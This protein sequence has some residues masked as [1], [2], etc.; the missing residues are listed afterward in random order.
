MRAK[1]HNAIY[2]ATLCTAIVCISY[3]SHTKLPP[4][5]MRRDDS[6]A[7]LGAFEI[8]ERHPALALAAEPPFVLTDTVPRFL[9][10]G[11]GSEMEQ[12]Q[13]LLTRRILKA[14]TGPLA[15]Q[16]QSRLIA[17][18]VGAASGWYSLYWASLG[19]PVIAFEPGDITNL[20]RAINSNGFDQYI[21]VHNTGISAV[22]NHG[23][24]TSTSSPALIETSMATLLPTQSEIIILKIDVE[25]SEMGV[26]QDV[27]TLIKNG[28]KIHNIIVEVTPKWWPE[29]TSAGLDVFQA[30]INMKWN[31]FSSPWSEHAARVGKPPQGL[32]PAGVI[33][34]WDTEPLLFVQQIPK[35]Q[36][37]VFVQSITYQ[38]DIWLQNPESPFALDAKAHGVAPL[39]CPDADEWRYAR[40]PWYLS[41]EI[42]VL[43][44]VDQYHAV[45]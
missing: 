33:L 28:T 30:F 8:P 32:A 3:I 6:T 7:P 31:V 43:Y 1:I 22:G 26:L 36:L 34:D 41:D 10:I 24:G 45:S 27:L 18:D 38:R 39:Q 9:S 40:M 42:N 21:T 37:A 19:F 14:V 5:H 17:V 13:T 23:S 29:S 11:E 12:S 20:R 2:L 4:R 44:C 16:L 25:G 35:D 15:M